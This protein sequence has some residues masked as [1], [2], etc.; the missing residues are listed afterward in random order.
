[1]RQQGYAVKITGFLPVD[2]SD[3]AAQKKA[4]DA[5]TEATSKGGDVGALIDLLSNVEFEQKLTSRVIADEPPAA[6]P[7]KKTA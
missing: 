3:L 1:M 2:K 7:I 4:I 5:L 6:V